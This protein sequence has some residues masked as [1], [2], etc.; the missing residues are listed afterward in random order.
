MRAALARFAQK[1]KGTEA[2]LFYYS[3]HGL[4][5]DGQNYLV[6]V[7]AQ[8]DADQVMAFELVKLTT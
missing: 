1:L 5:I 4:Q 7:D 8:V 2:A 3:G 6:P